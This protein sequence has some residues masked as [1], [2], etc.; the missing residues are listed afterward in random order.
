MTALATRRFLEGPIARCRVLLAV[1]A[2]A[3]IYL[4]PQTPLLARWVPF[5]SG[6]FMVDSRLFAILAM[7][8]AYSVI[9]YIGT[10][11]G[12]APR[13]TAGAVWA[14]MVFAVCI[15]V[16]TEGVTSPAYPILA[17]A[18]V[19]TSL[20]SGPRR[21][22]PITT[23]SLALYA[24]LLTI[25]TRGDT[26]VYILRP[27][28]LGIT[29]YLLVY[30]G[31]QRRDAEERLRA[32]EI[33]DQRQRIARDLHDGYAQALAGVNLRLEA[34]RAQL[35]AG[36]TAHVLGDL[37]RLQ[38]GVQR[39]YDDLRAYVRSLAGEEARRDQAPPC[40]RT[41]I[42]FRADIVAAPERLTSVLTIVRE[43]LSNIVRHA[44]A[45]T[46]AIEIAG[47]AGAVR[48][49]IADD[50]VGFRGPKPPWSID[51]RVREAGGH[52]RIAQPPAGTELQISLPPT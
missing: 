23:L 15:A 21:P 2:L 1:A 25:S 41:A 7:Y 24:G 4:D 14:D 9:L 22:A 17:F 19:S 16:L 3:S 10:V 37:T 29:G 38:S 50:G 48:I 39:E 34:A 35:A 13:I 6:H 52:I 32:L 45:R 31:R 47:D 44:G 43:G 49:T 27:L 30:L 51:S 42:R 18:V 26:E 5:V 40:G 11:R 36:A 33:T 28:Y 8:L 12:V 20:I 46:A